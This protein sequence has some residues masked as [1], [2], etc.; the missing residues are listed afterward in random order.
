MLEG[1][2]KQRVR[3]NGK[4]ITIFK[5]IAISNGISNIKKSDTKIRKEQTI[6]EKSNSSCTGEQPKWDVKSPLMKGGNVDESKNNN[7]S[8]RG[9]VLLR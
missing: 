7:K 2:Q 3:E 9:E 1:V 4:Q 5:G 6:Q 8:R